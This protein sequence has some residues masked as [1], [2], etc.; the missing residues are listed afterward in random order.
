[1]SLIL[2][3]TDHAK[4]SAPFSMWADAEAKTRQNSLRLCCDSGNAAPG[5]TPARRKK[6]GAGTRY[7]ERSMLT[8]ASSTIML[9]LIIGHAM[10]QLIRIARVPAGRQRRHPSNTINTTIRQ[11]R[12]NAN[13]YLCKS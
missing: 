10:K 11:G 13:L 1:M 7:L 4:G 8:L 3:N 2:I 6:R 12:G 5:H 9:V